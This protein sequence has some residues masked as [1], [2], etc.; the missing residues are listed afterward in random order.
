MQRKNLKDIVGRNIFIGEF[1]RFGKKN[2]WFKEEKTILLKNIK[3]LEGDY[4]C[5]HLWFG[6]TKGFAKLNLKYG[7]IIEFNARVN[8]YIKGYFGR[9]DDIY[10]NISKDYKLSYPTKMRKIEVKKNE[11]LPENT[12]DKIRVATNEHKKKWI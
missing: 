2:G 6:Y 7:D 4:V 10:K 9:K 3:F 1:E 8:S 5:D 12:T 11:H